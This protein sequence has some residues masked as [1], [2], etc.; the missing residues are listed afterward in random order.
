MTQSSLTIN[1]PYSPPLGRMEADIPL[2]K[3]SW[4]RVGGNADFLFRPANA[5]ELAEFLHSKPAAMPVTL[6]GAASNILIRDGGIAGTVIK[7]GAGFNDM[8]ITDDK[9]K[10]GAGT[11][12]IQLARFAQ[13]H[14]VGGLEFLSGIPGA[15]GGIAA[16]NAGAYG[17]EFRDIAHD[18]EG[19]LPDGSKARYLCS[20]LPMGY[21]NGGLPSGFIVTSMTLIGDLSACSDMIKH[22]MDE[23]AR[24][25]KAT[26]PTK[27]RTGGS[28]FKNP[29]GHKA[30]RLIDAAGLRGYRRNDA[31]I[32]PLHCNFLINLG[33]ASARDLEMLG[34][35][36]IDQ[37][38]QCTGIILE[39]ELIRI[40]R[41]QTAPKG[42]YHG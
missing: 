32:S 20:D 3:Y 23:I 2:A 25:R 35:Y 24:Q 18:I 17:S 8:I 36:A 6:L 16:M 33:N 10:V 41:H 28:T 15:M 9:I 34:E 39:W 4:L 7:L 5:L 30:W 21:R 40:G 31:Q 29:A 27:A 37:V 42:A 26:Q 14:C 1:I 22:K 11:L 19:V 38:R 13:Q 12:A